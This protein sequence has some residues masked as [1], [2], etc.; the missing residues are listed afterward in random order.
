MK[1]V[2]KLL[3]IAYLSFLDLTLHHLF[4]LRQVTRSPEK[5]FQG[6]NE[7][8]QSHYTYV[9]DTRVE[10]KP[11]KLRMHY[12]KEGDPNSS[13]VITFFKSPVTFIGSFN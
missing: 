10:W 4:L 1:R 7:P 2:K 12:L 13:E 6:I 9:K 5:N 11:Q 3:I 8:F